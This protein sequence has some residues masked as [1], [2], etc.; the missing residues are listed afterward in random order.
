ML[1]DNHLKTARTL[2][3]ELGPTR[4][5]SNFLVLAGTSCRLSNTLVL[6]AAA[7]SELL[8]VSFNLFC[9][10]MLLISFTQACVEVAKLKEK[11][12]TKTEECDE[13]RDRR[14]TLEQKMH[15]VLK[16]DD[17]R[18]NSPARPL[19][20]PRSPTRR[21]ITDQE[22]SGEKS[23]ACLPVADTNRSVHYG[24]ETGESLPI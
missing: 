5:L 7:C 19:P 22:V 16:E 1:T 4:L 3:K 10:F 8:S 24:Q 15:K 9:L 17:Q 2:S 14:Q 11:M 12:K 18:S 13:E 23:A 21:H 6:G 20:R